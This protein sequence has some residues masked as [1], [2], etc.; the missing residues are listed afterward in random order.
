MP[1]PRITI[2]NDNPDFLELMRELLEGRDYETV[3][4]ETETTNAEQ[5]AATTPDLLIIDLRLGSGEAFM[6]GWELVLVAKM[7]PALKSIPIILCTADAQFIRERGDEIRRL[8]GVHPILKP[9]RL[10]EMEALIA[11]LLGA[12]APAQA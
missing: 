5:L 11:R 7:H 12:P 4:L 3:T 8:A 6:T 9:F 10:D 1:R 2:L